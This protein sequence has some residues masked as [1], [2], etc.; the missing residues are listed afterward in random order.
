MPDRFY[1][2]EIE[3]GFKKGTFPCGTKKLRIFECPNDIWHVNM[4]QVDG[5]FNSLEPFEI[6]NAEVSQRSQIQEIIKFLKETVP[7]LKNISLVETAANI[8]VREGV[9]LVGEYVLTKDDIAGGRIFDDAVVICSNSIDMHG[10]SGVAYSTVGNGAN[11]S[12]PLRCLLAR[13]YDN[14]MAAG[15]CVSADRAALAAIRVMPPCFAM[16]EAAGTA[17]S[18]S[19]KEGES[20]KK[21][22]VEGLRKK[23]AENGAYIM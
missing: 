13:E 20:V 23:L 21:I 7:A 8:G 14:L 16:G 18:I 2:N 22:S 17:A 6:T 4:A 10:K 9:R 3:E 19:V 12:I 5:Q 11:Y 1:M 15:R